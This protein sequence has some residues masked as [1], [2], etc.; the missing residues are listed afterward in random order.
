MPKCSG[1]S[2]PLKRKLRKKAKRAQRR[3]V[4]KGLEENGHHARE[5]TRARK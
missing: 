5:R 3:T 4:Q 2:E 1:V